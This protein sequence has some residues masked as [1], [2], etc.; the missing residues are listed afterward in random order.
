M[1]ASAG[2]RCDYRWRCPCQHRADYQPFR[3]GNACRKDAKPFRWK[4]AGRQAAS[5]SMQISSGRSTQATQN[6]PL[7]VLLEPST[8][9][10][11]TIFNR[12]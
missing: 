1:Q 3:N 4:Y 5:A 2:E 10:L 8:F 9:C 12:A 6:A 7:I 11:N